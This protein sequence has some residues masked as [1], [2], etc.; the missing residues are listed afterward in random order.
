MEYSIVMPVYK[1]SEILNTCLESVSNQILKPLEIIIVNNNTTKLETSKLISLINKFK[2][3]NNISIRILPSSKNSGALARNLGA[4]AAKSEL[5][6]FLDSDVILDQDYYSILI[7]YFKK[8]HDLIAIQG[9]DRTLIDSEN[10][11]LRANVLNKIF[12]K[13]EQ[14]F[15]TSLLLNRKKAYVSPSLAVSHPKVLEN[16]EVSSQWIST[17]A[18]I[19]K[20][21]IFNKYSFPE[22]FITYSNNEY[23][24]FSYAL[25]QN[26]VGRMIYT[27]KAKY[28]DIQTVSGR[29]DRIPLLYQI[30][31]Y[32]YYIFNKLFKKNIKNI[33]IFIKSRLGYLIYH[34]LRLI[35]K[36]DTSIANYFHAFFSLI[37]PILHLSAIIKGDLSFYEK[38]FPIK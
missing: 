11:I 34:L 28:R 25:Y 26:N 19:F 12:Y 14:F 5:I 36:R 33:V 2:D 32:D 4:Y 10:K 35:V 16:F 21:D 38:D 27:S 22:Q 30:Q 18:G 8:Y 6:A 13:F 23:V 7:N 37:Y 24:M 29:I 17:C 1:R 20:K 3:N 31:S 15:E 9:L